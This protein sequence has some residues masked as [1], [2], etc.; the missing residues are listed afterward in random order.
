MQDLVQKSPFFSVII[1]IYKVEDYL[2]ECVDS[3]LH[4]EFENYEIILVDDG[5]P[6]NCPQICDDYA[7]KY[8]NIRVIHKPNGGLSDARNAGTLAAAGEYVIYLDS[9]DYWDIQ[10]LLSELEKAII[11][12]GKPDVVMFQGKKI[13]EANGLLEMDNKFNVEYINSHSVAES[14]ANMLQEQSYSMSACTKAIKRSVLIEKAVIFEKGLL[15]ED[16]DWFLKLI[17]RVESLKAV[18]ISCYVYRIR[19]GSISTSPSFKLVDD[20]IS[21]VSKWYN[22]LRE[23]EN[24]EIYIPCMGALSY[25]YMVA[26]LNYSYLGWEEKKKILPKFKKSAGVMKYAA[27]P[28][29]KLT[30][31]SLRLV[32][33]NLCSILLMVYYN[34]NK[35][36]K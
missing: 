36:Q 10:D 5:S 31:I 2:R 29:S 14:F 16:L 21:T 20:V 26:L 28:K 30:A 22:Q 9:D 34:R 4:Q 27:N 24:E 23:V 18:D 8:E 12:Y 3:V 15:G 11:E 6:D 35:R 1:P 33:I 19:K 7:S 32:G 17:T 25:A 13:F